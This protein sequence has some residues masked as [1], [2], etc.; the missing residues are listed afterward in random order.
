[1]KQFLTLTITALLATSLVSAQRIQNRKEAQRERIEQGVRSGELTRGE[2][3]RLREQQ[4]DIRQTV[5]RDRVDGGGLT[6]R[7]RAKIEKKQDRANR[8]IARQKHDAQRRP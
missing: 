4:R 1:M 2:A 6:P 7:E 5:R 3:A 8:S